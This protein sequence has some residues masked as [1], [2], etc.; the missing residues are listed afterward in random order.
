[1]FD[2]NFNL[3]AKIQLFSNIH[4]YMH[5]KKMHKK[6][7]VFLTLQNTQVY[8]STKNTKNIKIFGYLQKK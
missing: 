8:F 5:T 1:M 2:A 7:I 4:K 6:R 3:R